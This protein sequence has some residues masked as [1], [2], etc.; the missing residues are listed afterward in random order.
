MHM[1]SNEPL[2]RRTFLGAGAVAL[3]T[4]ALSY[5]RIIGANDRISLGHIGVGRRGRELASVVA[6]GPAPLIATWLFSRFRSGYAIAS[7]IFACAM[8]SIAAT[9]MLKDYTNRD[10]SEEYER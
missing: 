3:G 4:T 10:I 9:A 2:N 6:G 7:F 8:I 1:H 5:G